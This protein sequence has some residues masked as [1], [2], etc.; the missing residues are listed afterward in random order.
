MKLQYSVLACHS[1]KMNQ[2]EKVETSKTQNE[3]SWLGEI[4]NHMIF[5]DKMKQRIND[6]SRLCY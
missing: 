5:R 2:K 3:K 1:S 4:D 6:L